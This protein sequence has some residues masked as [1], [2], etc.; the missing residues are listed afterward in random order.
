MQQCQSFYKISGFSGSVYHVCRTHS[1]LSQCSHLINSMDNPK[2]NPETVNDFR[3]ISLLNSSLKVLSKLLANRL[4]GKTL[5]VIHENQYGFVRGKTIQDCL[6]WAFVYLHQCHQSK[7]GIVILKLDFEKAF[8]MVEHAVILEM[9]RAKG[10]PSKWIRWAADILSTT[11][12]S[13]LLNGTS[14]KEFK[15]KRG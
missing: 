11:T 7:R 5:Q 10:F 1:N 9:L 4:Q 12:S 15:C 14:G 2:D 8:D 13:V 3:P 6:G